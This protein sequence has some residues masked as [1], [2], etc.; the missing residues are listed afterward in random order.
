MR[1]DLRYRNGCRQI[2]LASGP[3]PDVAFMPSSDGLFLL[4][5]FYSH[6]QN[7]VHGAPIREQWLS[8]CNY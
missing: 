3:K 1:I 7:F 5:C 4:H 8:A 6:Y 2:N